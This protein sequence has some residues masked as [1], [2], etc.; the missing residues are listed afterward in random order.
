[1]HVNVTHSLDDMK[2][3]V[4][5]KMEHYDSILGEINEAKN[6]YVGENALKDVTTTDDSRYN[7]DTSTPRPPLQRL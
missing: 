4:M 5:I 7:I 6:Q 1:M 2:K 3:N